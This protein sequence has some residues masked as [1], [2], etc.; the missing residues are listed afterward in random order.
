MYILISNHISDIKSEAGVRY[1]YADPIV[2]M[3]CN[4]FSYH[5]GMEDTLEDAI[6]SSRFNIANVIFNE[7]NGKISTRHFDTTQHFPSK[8][9]LSMWGEK[10]FIYILIWHDM[11]NNA[12]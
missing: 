2:A 10:G 8:D 4:V 6:E 12:Y 3:L 1:T 7:Y 11:A 5:L 9:C